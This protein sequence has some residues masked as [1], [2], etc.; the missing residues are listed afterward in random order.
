MRNAF[1]ADPAT[2]VWVGTYRGLAWHRSSGDIFRGPAP[3]TG[4]TAA[5][6]GDREYDAKKPEPVAYQDRVLAVTL[7]SSSFR[8]EDSVRFRYRLKGAGREWLETSERRVMFPNLAPGEHSFE[9]QAKTP[10]SDWSEE[11]ASFDFTIEGPWWDVTWVRTG[12]ALFMMALALAVWLSRSRRIRKQH[13]MLESQV[14]ERARELIREKE[15]TEKQ[16]REIAELLHQSREANRLKDEF[17]ANMSHEIRTPMNGIIGM[18]SMALDSDLSGEQREYVEIAHSSGQ[19]LLTLLNDI[20]DLSK[21]EAGH[22][23]LENIP[24]AVRGCLDDAVN[25]LRPLARDKNLDLRVEVHHDTPEVL[26]GDPVRLRQ[27]ILNLLSNAVKFTTRGYIRLRCQRGVD[28]GDRVRLELSIEDTGIGIAEEQHETIFDIF[29]QA[30][31]S[32]TRRY[33]GTGLGLAI[34]ARLVGL[35]KGRIW[36][37][38]EIGQGSTFHFTAEFGAAD[39]GDID[40]PQRGRGANGRALPAG[41]DSPLTVLVAEDNPTNML[42]ARRL[43]EK[44]GCAVVEAGDGREM[45]E[46]LAHRE[47]DIALVDVQMPVM[48][49]L[50]AI[51]TLRAE[52]RKT[53]RHLPILA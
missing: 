21:I 42:L 51:A 3:K 12:L 5:R 36:L 25:T 16:K 23:D 24:F 49:G 39:P 41:F 46:I 26:R 13:E 18:T 17:L 30:D 53:G 43:L 7:G 50:T 31:G 33:G 29:E 28:A 2:G 14:A 45:L 15:R 20:L 4:I 11:P 6:F 1:L 19:S 10:V 47:V 37:D 22:V 44:H 48:D 34:C 52:E 38:S 9:A 35:M 40:N 32:I 8:F 27:V